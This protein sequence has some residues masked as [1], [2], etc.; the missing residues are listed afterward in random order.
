MQA[1]VTMRPTAG[2]GFQMSYT[3]SKN[4]SLLANSPTDPLDFD[5]DYTLATS[6]RTHV[7]TSYGTY[8]IPMG[9]NQPLFGKS[10]GFL[11]GLLENW[12]ASWIINASS[13]S[14]ANWTATSMLYGTGVPDQVGPFPFDQVG[15]YWEEGAYRGNYLSNSLRFV[16]DP[17]RTLVTT[18]DNLNQQCTLV[19]AADEDG[20]IILQNPLP[21]TRG[22]FGQNRLYNPG[23]WGV[24]MALSKLVQIDESKSVQVRVDAT[25][26]FNHP[27]PAGSAV[28]TTPGSRT[29]YAG[30]PALNLSGGTTYVGDLNSKV[31]QRTFQARVRFSF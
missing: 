2:L 13:G 30:P 28:Q 24:D 8:T 25:N 27:T 18:K 16:N 19:A 10:T 26:I 7:F 11:A 15:V 1:Q 4:L 6:D 22:N 21:G 3:W 20:N 23:S 12:Q 9:P 17:Q 5:A 31:G 29:Y 14:P